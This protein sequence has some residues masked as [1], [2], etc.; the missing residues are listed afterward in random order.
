MT[1]R[2][3]RLSQACFVYVILS[4]C[5]SSILY[6]QT[7]N[8]YYG[9]NVG[10][11]KVG[12]DNVGRDKVDGDNVGGNYGNAYDTGG[13][14]NYPGGYP[15]PVGYSAHAY[16]SVTG[17]RGFSYAQPTPEQALQ[18]AIMACISW[19]GIPNCCSSHAYLDQ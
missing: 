4:F 12:G 8:F 1:K 9:D 19:G 5:F 14:E 11:D 3:L 10:R 6:A 7:Y 15:L 16:C 18:V 2:I 13:R 17:A